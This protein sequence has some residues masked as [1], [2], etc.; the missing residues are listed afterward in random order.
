M[1]EGYRVLTRYDLANNKKQALQVNLLSF[2]LLIVLIGGAAAARFGRIRA[3]MMN[4]GFSV[5]YK[6]QPWLIMLAA[7]LVYVVLHE[8]T[9]AVVMRMFS[10]EKVHFGF[11]KGYAYAG[12]EALYA[13]EPYVLIALAPLV[14]WTII[15]CGL[16]F[17]LPEKW[18]WTLWFLQAFNVSGS[19]GDIWVTHHVVRLPLDVR[20][21][22]TGTDMTVYEP[23]REKDAHE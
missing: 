9:H 15:F 6:S 11:R 3:A 2:I 23:V 18:F 4:G 8:A 1:P 7:L 19:A 17:V 14:V 16:I 20:I 22:D 21:L 12:S 10:R 5:W 13:R